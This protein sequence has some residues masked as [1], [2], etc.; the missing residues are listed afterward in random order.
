MRQ[1]EKKARLLFYLFIYLLLLNALVLHTSFTFFSPPD[2]EPVKSVEYVADV[3]TSPAAI[4]EKNWQKQALPDDWINSHQSKEQIWYRSDFTAQAGGNTVWAIYLPSVAHN[5]AVYIN[6][7]WVGQG[8]PFT[9][10][11]SR[12]H[13]NPLLFRFSSGLLFQQGINQVDIRVKAASYRQGRLGEFYLAPADQ[14]EQ[15][16]R[17]KKLIRVN[18]VE[19]ITAAMY[20]MALM[21]LAFWLARPQDNIYGLFALELFIWATHN[22]NLL[23]SDIP[24][25]ARLW[26][27][28]N[29]STLGWTVIVLIIFNYRFLDSSHVLIERFLQLFALS[30]LS[31]FF[32]PDVDSVL[33]IGYR[34]WDVF[35]LIFGCYAIFFLLRKFWMKPDWDIFLMLLVGLPIL[36]SGLHDILVLN[37]YIDPGQGLIMQFSVV[38]AVLLFSWFLIRRF[39]QSID[40]AEHLAANLEMR[41]EQK[42]QQLETQ[43]QAL[44]RLQKQHVLA[45]ERERIM[46]DMHDGI[47]GQLLAVITYLHDYTGEVFDKVRGRVQHSLTDL[48]CVIDS[49]DPLYNELPVLLGMMRIRLQDQLDDAHIELEWAVT[50]LPDFPDISP[51]RSLHIM[52]IVQEAITNGIKH[53]NSAKMCLAT[54]IDNSAP[55]Q[56]FID[57]IDY[58]KGVGVALSEN[59]NASRGVINMRH[60]AEQI[61]AELKITSSDKGTCVRL[62][63]PLQ[64]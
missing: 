49:L 14:L 5:A 23:V 8:G 52:R 54:G 41:V 28:M 21:I 12:H 26:E 56:V 59:H 39:V 46:R 2:T 17:F 47:G 30:A 61:G 1:P 36:V 13:N 44:Q 6:G 15:A 16:Y 35:I 18:L 24:V 55:G 58:G 3:A 11:V 60:R 25:S 33:S 50:D 45:E 32:L 38:P 10:P 29:M 20:A 34:V 64:P 53:S 7:V 31:L 9:S 37:Q 42:K 63:L 43:Y 40:R 4:T 48:R 57:V 27:A 19:W 62:L 51:G 22:L